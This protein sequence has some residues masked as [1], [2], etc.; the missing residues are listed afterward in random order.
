MLAIFL[1]HHLFDVELSLLG[2]LNAGL[3]WPTFFWKRFH[4]SIK[5]IQT[6]IML[7]VADREFAPPTVGPCHCIK[8]LP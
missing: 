2:C 6:D 5:Q 8:S 1:T 3:Q 7:Q 4:R